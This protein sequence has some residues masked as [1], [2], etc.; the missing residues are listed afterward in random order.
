MR[1]LDVL[2]KQKIIILDNVVI[3]IVLSFGISFIVDA[4]TSMIENK[5]IMFLCLGLFCILFVIIIKILKFYTSRKHQ[6]CTNSLFIVDNKAQLGHVPRYFFNEEFVRILISICNENKTFKECWKKS[7]AKENH[8]P[9]EKYV[10]HDFVYIGKV[11]EEE[12]AKYFKDEKICKFVNELTEYVFIDW[13]SRKLES[14][15]GNNI[16]NIAVLHRNDVAD[17]VLDNRVLDI[18]SRPFDEREKFLGKDMDANPTA[19]IYTLVGEDNVEFNKFELKLPPKTRLYK[20][21]KDTLIISGKYFKIKFHSSF[22]GFN[23]DIPGD[24]HRFYVSTPNMNFYDISLNMEISLKPFFFLFSSNWQNLLWIDMIC[25]AFL[26]DFSYRT[27]INDI[28]FNQ[29]ITN[30]MLY[31]RYIRQMAKATESK[32]ENI[33]QEEETTN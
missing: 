3:V 29:S 12:I 22:R 30:L 28:G 14:Y 1:P 20:E 25:E 10:S 21:G 31:D 4:L 19:E 5:S 6:I 2:K 11:S 15:F 8:E 16:K 27:F 13:L 26:H 24:F 9:K 18:I 17:Y 33:R 32:K 7:F 23:A